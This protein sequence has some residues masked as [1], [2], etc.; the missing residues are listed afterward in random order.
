MFDALGVGVGGSVLGAVAAGLAIMPF[1][2]YKYGERIRARS[3]FAPT[4]VPPPQDEEA[5]VGG[6]Q[7]TESRD[8]T[9]G[10]VVGGSSSEGE[11]TLV[12]VP[13]STPPNEQEK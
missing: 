13:P 9:R 6:D 2:F 1:V 5:K 3:K 8:L 4:A 10:G 11:D 12:N 7:G